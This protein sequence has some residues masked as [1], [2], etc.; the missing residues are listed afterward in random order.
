M[1]QREAGLALP[2]SRD[3]PSG[4]GLLREPGIG[5]GALGGNAGHPSKGRAQVRRSAARRCTV[6]DAPGTRLAARVAQGSNPMAYI[7]VGRRRPL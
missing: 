3:R 5:A 4:A 6:R 7:E 2:G 1:F